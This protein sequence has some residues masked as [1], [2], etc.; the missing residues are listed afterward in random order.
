MFTMP[1][2][3]PVYYI[4]GNH[5]VGSVFYSFY[6]DSRLIRTYSLGT[7]AKFSPTA[8]ERYK[9]HFGALNQALTLANHTLVLID[10]PGLVDEDAR[11]ARSRVPLAEWH[12]DHG[13]AYD[14]VKQTFGPG[15]RRRYFL[16][17]ILFFFLTDVGWCV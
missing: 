16:A 5:D 11:R 6:L 13:G 17:H 12:P 4:P 9:S 14:F 15:E 8:I 7:T 1:E 2:Q 3:T 10:A